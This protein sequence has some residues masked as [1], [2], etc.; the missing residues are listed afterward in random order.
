MV[1]KET[2]SLHCSGGILA[3]DQVDFLNLLKSLDGSKIEN[4]P[5]LFFLAWGFM[6]SFSHRGWERQYQP[7]LLYL[8]K[9]LL[10]EQ[11]Q[12]LLRKKSVKP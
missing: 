11:M 7:L 1:Q 6:Q 10:I 12:W 8:R 5:L 4:P 2:S 9:D 3:D